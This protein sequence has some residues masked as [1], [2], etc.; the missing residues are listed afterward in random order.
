MIAPES[1]ISNYCSKCCGLFKNMHIVT[2]RKRDSD[3]IYCEKCFKENDL[4]VKRLKLMLD[5]IPMHILPKNIVDDY[6][7]QKPK[8]FE[9]LCRDGSIHVSQLAL[10][11]SDFYSEM[12]KGT[13]FA[14]YLTF[15]L[16][17]H[18]K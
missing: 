10:N 2:R 1:G 9:F 15:S 3:A 6:E 14:C 11:I 17:T 12:C 4:K 8:D 5:A 16:V 13:V 7:A 18:V